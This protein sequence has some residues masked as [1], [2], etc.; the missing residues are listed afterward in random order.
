MR[1]TCPNCDAQYEVAADAIPAN[2]RDVQCSNCGH[3]W[4]EQ[5]ETTAPDPIPDPLSAGPEP[6]EAPDADLTED[7]PSDQPEP[8]EEAGEDT[9]AHEDAPDFETEADDSHDID[10]PD[11]AVAENGGDADNAEGEAEDEDDAE[12]D[13]TADTEAEPENARPGPLGRSRRAI[14]PE[15]ADLLREEAELEQAA[16]AAEQSE[17]LESQTDMD[18]VDEGGARS[19][20]IEGDDAPT[21]IGGPLPAP[22]VDT[23]RRERLPDIEEINSSLNPGQAG[24]SGDGEAGLAESR[25]RGFR[26]GFGMICIVAA[27][28]AFLY[29][30]S[31]EIS[32]AVPQLEDALTR[33]TSMVDQGRLWLDLRV[34]SIIGNTG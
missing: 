23:A 5:P 30:G 17:A 10:D 2:G 19:P 26:L 27:I 18:F 24:G 12:D 33:Y 28:L 7:A 32:S 3:V 9:D 25:S 6:E 11:A 8:V 4:F 21:V 14:D 15:V 34:Q 16:R 1:L 31:D 22:D 13:G 29:L 20:A